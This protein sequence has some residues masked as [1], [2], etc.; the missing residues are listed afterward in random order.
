MMG[1]ADQ[2]NMAA[3]VYEVTTALLGFW[4]L[5]LLPAKR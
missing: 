2:Y 4:A 1:Q 5:R 3:M